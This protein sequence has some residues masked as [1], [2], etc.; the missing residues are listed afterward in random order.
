MILICFNLN[1]I[2]ILTNYVNVSVEYDYEIE[3]DKLWKINIFSILISSIFILS[4]SFLG[5]YFLS[6]YKHI[7]NAD[8]FMLYSF[9]YANIIY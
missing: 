3:K 4:V 9:I 8:N 2:A 7:P 5:Y 6:Y 1:G